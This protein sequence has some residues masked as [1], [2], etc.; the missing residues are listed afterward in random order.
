M[1]E[2]TICLPAAL[3]TQC[4]NACKCFVRALYVLHVQIFYGLVLVSF[5]ASRP[6]DVISRLMTSHC[7]ACSCP[8]NNNGQLTPIRQ[9]C[10]RA[11]PRTG[12]RKFILSGLTSAP[13]RCVGAGCILHVQRM[14]ISYLVYMWDAGIL[15]FS[16]CGCWKTRNCQEGKGTGNKQTNI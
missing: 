12:N 15:Y 4:L 7:G 14:G 2:L 10:I 5:H 8:P 9:A 13:A 11:I 6:F 16:V 1:F 3:R